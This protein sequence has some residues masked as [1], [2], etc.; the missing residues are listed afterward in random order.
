MKLCIFLYSVVLAMIFASS[1]AQRGLQVK[2]KKFKK[3]RQLMMSKTSS[4]GGGGGWD[5]HTG[6]KAFLRDDTGGKKK[7]D[8][9]NLARSSP[10]S[11]RRVAPFPE[12]C[13]LELK[14]LD[15]VL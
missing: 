11:S 6:W 5:F 14:P 3:L 7:Q 15:T 8:R 10:K 2:P 1:H 9:E 12:P 13:C 4:S